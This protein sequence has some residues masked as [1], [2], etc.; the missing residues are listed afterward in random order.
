MRATVVVSARTGKI[1]S[2]VFSF[3]NLSDA[4][5]IDTQKLQELLERLKAEITFK[6]LTFNG[7][8]SASGFMLGGFSFFEP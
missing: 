2:A 6:N 4:L 5:T 8:K 1:V 3:D 7:Q